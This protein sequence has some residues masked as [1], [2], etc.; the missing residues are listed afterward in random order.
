MVKRTG[1]NEHITTHGGRMKNGHDLALQRDHRPAPVQASVHLIGDAL[2][3]VDGGLHDVEEGANAAVH[4]AE[5][6]VSVFHVEVGKDAV[7]VLDGARVD[8]LG[9]SVDAGGGDLVALGHDENGHDVNEVST[10]VD[11]TLGSGAVIV[12]IVHRDAGRLRN[13]VEDFFRRVGNAPYT[14]PQVGEMLGGAVSL[15]QQQLL[16]KSNKGYECFRHHHHAPTQFPMPK[17]SRIN[18]GRKL[19]MRTRMANPMAPKTKSPMPQMI[20]VWR[21][22]CFE[23]FRAM[24]M[25][26]AHE[27]RVI[28]RN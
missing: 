12:E 7:V 21:N 24:R 17:T 8:P 10:H 28:L 18:Q 22:S 15:E 23:G 27:P 1:F 6:T 16:F 26:R 4:L 2:L 3:G 5:K 20:A 9:S 13:S 19:S 25:I 14:V 11:A